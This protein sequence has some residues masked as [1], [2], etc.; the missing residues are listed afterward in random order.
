MQ[1][2]QDPS[3]DQTRERFR[4]FATEHLAGDRRRRDA[5]MEFSL[6]RWRATCQ[7][8]LFGLSMPREVGGE[9]LPYG[10]T[11]AAL[12]GL[13]EGCHDTGMFFA[14]AS[15]I[16][17]TQLALT[18]HGSPELQEEY[19]PGLITGE[20]LSCLG[21]SEMGAGSDVYSIQTRAERT[22]G[23]WVLTGEKAFTTNSLAATCCLVFART[24]S[25]SPTVT[26]S[27]RWA[28]A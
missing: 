17:G 26:S 25:S 15:Q 13:C 2:W 7:E 28:E 24:A 27:E 22:E 19:L 23:G 20:R 16:S 3:L 4:S 8:G 5:E 12:E 1:P 6:D 9:A 21:F 14:M 11:I 10:H 18:T